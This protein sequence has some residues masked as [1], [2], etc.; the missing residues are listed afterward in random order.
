[1]RLGARRR[2][3]DPWR[4]DLEALAATMYMI[5]QSK[6][7]KAAA[8]RLSIMGQWGEAEGCRLLKLDEGSLACVDPTFVAFA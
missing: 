6:A 8:L 4:R 7:R 2:G 1:M 5:W 3:A